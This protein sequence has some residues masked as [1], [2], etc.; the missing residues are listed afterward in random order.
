MSLNRCLGFAL[1]H[2]LYGRKDPN[3]RP[4]SG[5]SFFKLGCSI[6]LYLGH[7]R[8]TTPFYWLGLRQSSVIHCQLTKI[9][10][11]SI[12]RLANHLASSTWVCRPMFKG[13]LRVQFF[14]LLFS[15]LVFRYTC[16]FSLL[17]LLSIS[18]SARFF[19]FFLSPTSGKS[20]CAWFIF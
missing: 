20:I 4:S 18:S 6:G 14:S 9:Q 5:R 1:D 13:C 8:V 12:K 17:L 3:A 19:C 15:S 11:K 7:F 2:N 16:T 10:P